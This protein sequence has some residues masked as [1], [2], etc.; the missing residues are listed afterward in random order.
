MPL[1]FIA[2][3]FD[4]TELQAA[5][6]LADGVQEARVTLRADAHDGAEI[7]LRRIR[8]AV[9]QV[10]PLRDEITAI[11]VSTPGLLDSRRGI[12]RALPGCPGWE[13]V[14]LQSALVEALGVPVFIGKAADTA[15]LGEHRFGVGRDVDDLIYMAMNDGLESGMIFQNQIFTGGNGMGGE[16]GQ[17]LVA[18][19]DE[20]GAVP[21]LL[22]LEA[23]LSND[24]ILRRAREQL[25]AGAPTTL[26]PY[27][28]DH[29]AALTIETLCEVAPQGDALAQS[30]LRETG[31]CLGLALVHLM[32]L[33]DP[34]LFVLDG[35]ALRAGDVLLTA[36]RQTLAARAPAAYRAHARIVLAQLGNDVRLWGALALCLSELGL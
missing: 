18:W 34:T 30:V 31:V 17:L 24:A 3:T 2:V 14:P 13:D 33:F 10:W 16:I 27:F 28:R 4:K 11:G 12:L 8:S 22:P 29:P 36:A 26:L 6:Y 35:I 19:P 25:M 32:Y 15:A 21:Q 9:R 5:R 20:A 7:G 23:L 1:R